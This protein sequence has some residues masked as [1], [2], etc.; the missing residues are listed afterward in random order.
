MPARRLSIR[1]KTGWPFCLVGRSINAGHI[2]I[3]H[4]IF[5]SIIIKVAIKCIFQLNNSDWTYMTKQLMKHRY[6]K[7]KKAC[8]I[9]IDVYVLEGLKRPT[10]ALVTNFSAF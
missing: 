6:N 2:C 3:H 1:A 8:N 10:N 5:I 9:C 4:S 7:K